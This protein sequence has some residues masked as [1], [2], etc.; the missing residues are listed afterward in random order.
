MTKS[1]KDEDWPTLIAPHAVIALRLAFDSFMRG[2]RSFGMGDP[3]SPVVSTMQEGVWTRDE[4]GWWPESCRAEH[5]RDEIVRANEDAD[6]GN[7][8]AW[9]RE[10]PLTDGVK[11]IYALI[12]AIL[13]NEKIAVWGVKEPAVPECEVG[14]VPPR[15]WW[16]EIKIDFDQG[17][18]WTH[19]PAAPDQ[20]RLIFSDIKLATAETYEATVQPAP[21]SAIRPSPLGPALVA[22][23]VLPRPRLNLKKLVWDVIEETP[24]VKSELEAMGSGRAEY[25]SMDCLAAALMRDHRLTEANVDSVKREIHQYRTNLNGTRKRK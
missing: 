13:D 5:C 9:T 19:D 22:D 11:R 20:W 3:F 15:W 17:K 16:R 18:M 21:E 12:G 2:K 14:L 23:L 8:G 7:A 25:G 10:H 1:L 24:A 6:S 4:F